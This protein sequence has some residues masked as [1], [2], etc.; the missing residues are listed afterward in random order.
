MFEIYTTNNASLLNAQK[1]AKQL[2]CDA[3]LISFKFKGKI[4]V[5]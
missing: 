2:N 1:V 4:D 3:D 5:F